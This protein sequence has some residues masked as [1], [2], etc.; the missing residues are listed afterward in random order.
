MN[1]DSTQPSVAPKVKPA[2]ELSYRTK[3]VANNNER[4]LEL[5]W[6]EATPHHAGEF[7]V[8]PAAANSDGFEKNDDVVFTE[9]LPRR[10]YPHAYDPE[11]VSGPALA[12]LSDADVEAAQA[13]TAYNEGDIDSVASRVSMVAAL[14]AKAYPHTAFNAALGAAVSFIRRATLLMDTS[15]LSMPDL[16]ALAKAT[17]VLAGNPLLSLEQSA[18]LVIEMEEQDWQG[19]DQNVAD[20]VN[21]LFDADRALDGDEVTTEKQVKD[22]VT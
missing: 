4:Q 13:V 15:Q 8:V 21:A 17:R 2:R 11:G 19:A 18:D 3:I 22:I 14:M 10:A 7:E 12:L 5:N 1:T 16:M 6:T 20:F 9:E